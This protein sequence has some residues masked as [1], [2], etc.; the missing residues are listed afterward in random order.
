ML[1]KRMIRG[2]AREPASAAL[3]DGR[4]GQT[5]PPGDAF[6]IRRPQA[7]GE[8]GAT[9]IEYAMIAGLVALVIFSAVTVLGTSVSGLYS[10][11]VDGF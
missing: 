2:F 9:A 11:V 6:V 5:Q 3:P 1:R 10:S 4:L 8:S 7:A